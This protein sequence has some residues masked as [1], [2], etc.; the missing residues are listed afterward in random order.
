MPGKIPA[1]KQCLGLH[2]AT[3][4]RY[5]DIF[6]TSICKS[7]NGKSV[8]FQSR[9]FS[10]NAKRQAMDK[11]TN[12]TCFVGSRADGVI[13]RE[14]TGKNN[15]D[16]IGVKKARV[17]LELFQVIQANDGNINDQHGGKCVYC[18]RTTRLKPTVSR[19][20]S[21]PDNGSSLGCIFSLDHE[22][23]DLSHEHPE[24]HL[25][26][27]CL[28]CNLMMSNSLP[29]ERRLLLEYIRL[30]RV[31]P[32]AKDILFSDEQAEKKRTKAIRKVFRDIK[33][34]QIKLTTSTCPP[35]SFYAFLAW[36]DDQND[37]CS[38]SGIRGTW[39][40]EADA[41]KR[42][43]KL[44]VDRIRSDRP[45]EMDNLQVIL[46][47][48]NCGKNVFS[49]RESIEWI[50]ALRQSGVP[51]ADRVP[52]FDETLWASNTIKDLNQG[53][54]V[55]PVLDERRVIEPDSFFAP[56]APSTPSQSFHCPHPTLALSYHKNL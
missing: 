43:L 12:A 32:F 46:W 5:K 31:S 25:Q 1:S 4:S 21:P 49:Q 48:L 15:R 6:N 2:E 22:R 53:P 54:S 51:Y 28:M 14:R 44:S 42:L 18:Q 34:R 29:T 7:S 11:S 50:A 9:C 33:D 26:V 41:S 55:P 19:L 24:Q 35:F 16:S 40:T 27:N 36:I 13:K 30:D 52:K 10:C 39:I 56:Y 17:I 23:P 8:I 20:A 45:Y 47:R 3:C 38:L 37:T